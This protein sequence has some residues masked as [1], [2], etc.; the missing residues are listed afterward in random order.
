[1]MDGMPGPRPMRAL[2]FAARPMHAI[3]VGA[4]AQKGLGKPR[5]YAPFSLFA[6]KRLPST[7]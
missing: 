6:H 4:W 5:R 3:G 1:M 2:V 7:A